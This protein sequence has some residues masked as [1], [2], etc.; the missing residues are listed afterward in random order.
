MKIKRL[1]SPYKEL[2]MLRREQFGNTNKSFLTSSF[3]WCDTPEGDRFW[4]ELDNGH[5]PDIPLDSLIELN[6]ESQTELIFKCL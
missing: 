5:Y 4:D 6:T 3:V 1:K 2:A